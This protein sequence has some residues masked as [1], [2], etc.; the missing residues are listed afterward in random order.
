MF[1]KVAIFSHD[2]SENTKMNVHLYP[3]IELFCFHLKYLQ[4][5]FIDK[6]ISHLL[7]Y[8]KY[9]LNNFI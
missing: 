4:M 7:W 3:F 8:V 9:V 6:Y 1:F 2:L 5:E